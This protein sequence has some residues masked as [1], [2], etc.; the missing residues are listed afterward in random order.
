M[1]DNKLD[2][3]FQQAARGATFGG[4]EAAWNNMKSR[5]GKGNIQTKADSR[6]HIPSKWSLFLILLLISVAG[7]TPILVNELGNDLFIT[8]NI[9]ESD[10]RNLEDGKGI[11]NSNSL[12]TSIDSESI[13]RRQYFEQ[14]EP[15]LDKEKPS[16]VNNGISLERKGDS[17]NTLFKTEA[18]GFSKKK[19]ENYSISDERLGN[20]KKF[21]LKFEKGTSSDFQNSIDKSETSDPVQDSF[22]EKPINYSTNNN[23]SSF[24]RDLFEG[25]NIFPDS[26]FREPD[27]ANLVRQNNNFLSDRASGKKKTSLPYVSEDD[28]DAKNYTLLF[29]GPGKFTDPV[30]R[31]VDTVSLIAESYPNEKNSEEKSFEQSKW[32]F[33]L[34]FSPDLSGTGLTRVENSGYNIGVSVEYHL[35]DKFSIGSG[36]TYSRKNYF[37]DRDLEEYPGAEANLD[38]ARVNALCNVLDIPVNVNYYLAGRNRSGFILGAGLSTYFMLTEDYELLYQQP[39]PDGSVSVR[40]ENQHF[41]GLVNASFGY[42]KIISP[43]LSFQVEPFVKIPLQGIGEGGIDLFTSGLRFTMKFSKIRLK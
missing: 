2:K 3:L 22:L 6:N 11:K 25:S 20:T 17:E 37:S 14:T 43:S 27:T 19:N 21:P 12:N 28:I 24:S 32:S 8:E 9:Q 39:W 10:L 34:E 36:I 38:L 42:R 41:F 13:Q 16:V 7:S 26:V 18:A 33:G 4:E 35:S 1:K 23:S 5:L 31:P 30:I 40:N 15:G 29:F